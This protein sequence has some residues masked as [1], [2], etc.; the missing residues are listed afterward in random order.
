MNI[1]KVRRSLADNSAC[2][3]VLCV[4]SAAVAS[5]QET[6]PP[7]VSDRPPQVHVDP[8]T[9][10]LPVVD[11]TDL[12]FRRL[13]TAQGLSQTR[14]AQILQDDQGFLWFGYAAR[15]EP[16][17]WL[18]VQGLRPRHGTVGQLERRFHL[19]AV[20]G[21][22]RRAVGRQRSVPRSIRPGHRDLHAL[23]PRRAKPDRHPHQRGRC[24]HALAG[25]RTRPLSAGTGNRQS[26]QVRPRSRQSAE[27][28][29]QRH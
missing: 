12:R 26:D 6:S 16:V 28:E 5:A 7:G 9:I 11:G 8:R 2:A 19:L 21:P 13:S 14:V 17:R 10:S 25:Y 18:R 15:P 1:S 29:Q 27:P 22:V 4:V 23:P 20:Q 24:R 3:L